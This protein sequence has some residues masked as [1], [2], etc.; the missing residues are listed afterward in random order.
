[1]GEARTD[2]TGLRWVIAH[3]GPGLLNFCR[4]PVG[5]HGLPENPVHLTLGRKAPASEAPKARGNRFMALLSRPRADRLS[6]VGLQDRLPIYGE[7]TL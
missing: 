3:R 7:R 2:R 6:N 1:M 5:R 4:L